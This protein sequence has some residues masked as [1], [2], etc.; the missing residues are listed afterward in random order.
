MD[1]MGSLEERITESLPR[2]SP[3]Q[4]QL[5]HFMLD[6][7]YLVSFAS[8]GQVGKKVHASAATV[9]RFAQSLGYQGFHE[10]RAAVREE[11]PTYLTAV[12]RIQKRLAAPPSAYDIPQQVFHTDIKNIERTASGLDEAHLNAALDEIVRAKQILVIGCGLSAASVL[13]L[14][15]SLKVMGFNVRMAA[16][17]GLTLATDIA[18]VTPDTL[19]IAI[20]LWRYARSIVQAVHAA[21]RQGAHIIAITD[22]AASPLAQA[23]DYTFEAATDGT[24]HSLSPSAV[25]SLL[26]V[27]IAGLSYRVPDQ[28]MDSLRHVDAMYR[29]QNLLVAE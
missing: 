4:K 3:K 6:N 22:S 9:V 13:F 11:L 7:K 28:V 18:Q 8:A 29:T 25:I 27:F 23:A 21:R 19:V 20:D 5:A 16:D 26:N 14:T 12:E 15:H 10:L 24:A 2:L 17:G 1:Q